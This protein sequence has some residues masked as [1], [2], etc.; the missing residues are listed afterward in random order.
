MRRAKKNEIVEMKDADA[1]LFAIKNGMVG[2]NGVVDASIGQVI[3][4]TTFAKGKLISAGK[5]SSIYFNF[6][7]E[8]GIWKLDLT[9]LFLLS[10]QALKKMI[11]ATGKSE[12]DLLIEI[13]ESL[14]GKKVGSDIW[15]PIM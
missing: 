9:A 12:N 8:A 15:K 4:D 2:K 11:E 13:L 6:Y 3:V 5:E 7:K 1:F 14:T 10:N